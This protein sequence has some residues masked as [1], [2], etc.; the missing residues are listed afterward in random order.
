MKSWQS[1]LKE[2]TFLDDEFTLEKNNSDYI[3]DGVIK[4][5]EDVNVFLDYTVTKL[6]LDGAHNAGYRLQTKDVE[7]N[8][9]HVL[10]KE[11]K[12]N[13][14]IF[15]FINYQQEL[16]KCYV[17][18]GNTLNILNDATKIVTQFP[19]IYNK[20]D[21]VGDLTSM[22]VNLDSKLL[23]NE[24]NYINFGFKTDYTVFFKF[25]FLFMKTMVDKLN[26]TFD[27]KP[28]TVQV[29]QPEIE[30][31]SDIIDVMSLS[32][33]DSKSE[34]VKNF[35]SALGRVK[36]KFGLDMVYKGTYNESENE[37][38]ISIN[39]VNKDD[40]SDILVKLCDTLKVEAEKL[41]MK[42]DHSHARTS[43]RFIRTI[44]LKY[45]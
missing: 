4:S 30:N 28:T 5:Y 40:V 36:T 6:I 15:E 25:M 31:I 35:V 21:F 44:T 27:S 24:K 1:I 18:E 8:K 23:I 13:A 12:S 11:Y 37:Y 38:T 7:N 29:V 39:T 34:L 45:T 20:F 16:L 3:V 32:L 41:N 19:A 10:I 42:Y 33:D 17:V 43:Q 2:N 9:V 14:I 26:N 22:N